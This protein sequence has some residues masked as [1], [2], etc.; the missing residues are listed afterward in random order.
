MRLVETTNNCAKRHVTC[1][2]QMAR[3]SKRLSVKALEAT[4]T[5]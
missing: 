3:W 5:D 1:K 2:G 4:R